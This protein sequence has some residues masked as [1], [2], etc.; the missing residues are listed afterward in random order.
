MIDNKLA[1][2]NSMLSRT[3]Q[4]RELA[5]VLFKKLFAELPNQIDQLDYALTLT[6]IPQAIA[7]SHKLHGSMSFCGFTELEQ[8]SKALEMSL[9]ANDLIP[10]KENFLQLKQKVND[11]QQIEQGILQ[12]LSEY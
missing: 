10:A 4:N 5:I 8:C 9:L 3:V 6:Q 12:H 1:Y 11:F 7:I 2:I